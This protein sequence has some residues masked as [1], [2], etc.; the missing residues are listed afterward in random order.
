MEKYFDRAQVEKQLVSW[1]EQEGVYATH[2]DLHNELYSVDTPPPT[3]S[4][5]L[6]IG[7]IFSYTQT[8]VLVRF[9]RMLGKSI[10]YPM[11]FDDNG[12]PTERFVE[13]ARGVTPQSVGPNEFRRV[14]V[15]AVAGVEDEF[16]D[17]WKQLGLSVD[18]NMSY[19]TIDRRTQKISQESFVRLFQKGHIY[20]KE[21]PALYCTAYQTSVSQADLEDIEK[22]TL[23]TDIAF[24]TETDKEVVI[25]TT[26]P[27]LL[28]S[29]VALLF[30]PDDE[31]YRYL[32]GQ[33]VQVPL[34]GHWVPVVA[35]DKVQVDKGTG[36][37]M[38]C[39]FGDKTDI[40]WYKRHK[41]PY[42]QT[43]GFDGRMMPQA[44]LIAGLK[45][46]EARKKILA[47]LEEVGCVRAQKTITHNV[48]IYERSKR[49][50]EYL[51]LSQ[52]FVKILP[53]K[54]ELLALADT[55]VWNPSFMK[56]RFVDWVSNLQWD[57]CISRQRYSGVPFPVWYDK[58]TGEPYVSEI[59]ALPVDP[60]EDAFPGTVPAGVD[61]VPDTEVMDTWNTSSL[62]P[63]ICKSL[64]MGTTEG[65]FDTQAGPQAFLPMAVR[66]Q[67]HDII[68]TWAFYTMV[69][70]YLHNGCLPWKEIVISGHVLS[71]DGGKIS[72]SKGN[73]PLEPANLLA[74][75]PADVIRYW[76][77]AGTLGQDVAF[78]ENTL[79][80]GGKLLNK[81]WNAAK[82]VTEHTQGIDP[83]KGIDVAI[84]GSLN[85]WILHRVSEVFSAY[86]SYF[87]R[88]EFSLALGAVEQFFWNDY[89]DNYLEYIKPILFKPEAYERALVEAT[90]V[91]L[92]HVTLR[93]LQLFAPC[94]PF[95]TEHLYQIMFSESV[96]FASLHTTKFVDVQKRFEFG[97][98]VA[99]V[100]LFARV[101]DGI[102]KLKS[103]Q[104]LS[105]K[106]PLASC[107]IVCDNQ[108]VVDLRSLETIL[109]P[110]MNIEV[111][112]YAA[113][114]S[115]GSQLTNVGDAWH[116]TVALI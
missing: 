103:E 111:V 79:K 6:H 35:D 22:E 85:Q 55:L 45:V 73:N 5:K 31:R 97:D 27:E 23:F 8:D 37:V 33:N 64:F 108:V 54:E 3:V 110:L 13:L 69:K 41:F 87:E 101:V 38:C 24:Q 70:S 52:W 107:V 42:R 116:A 59:S 104:N 49:E 105:L 62:T 29:C 75:Y 67:A 84:A 56:A 92:A 83:I 28:Y 32:L 18:W 95:V 99:R 48:S 17:L 15:E 81:L 68:R 57:W 80:I 53:F 14:C 91:V 60:R 78:S 94:M 1:W 88:N 82:F 34:S 30:H 65:L 71:R 66:P 44:G 112:E 11:G 46:P 51:M 63:Y 102:R 10:F 115:A 109:S 25:S 58:N 26:R 74:T 7:H 21:E 114:S 40:E 36:L 100:Q 20:R 77:T 90:R 4:G 19:S 76:T 89:C 47:I 2:H 113:T 50:V 43:I 96:G 9:N 86:S 61:L 106:V 93:L 16:R 72:K 39:T 12:L 98:A